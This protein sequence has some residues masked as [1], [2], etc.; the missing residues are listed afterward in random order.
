M[1]KLTAIFSRSNFCRSAARHD[2]IFVRFTPLLGD[3]LRD[4]ENDSIKKKDLKKWRIKILKNGVDAIPSNE[5]ENILF[6]EYI[7]L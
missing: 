7:E 4:N 2:Q 5:I 1:D 6:V 3:S